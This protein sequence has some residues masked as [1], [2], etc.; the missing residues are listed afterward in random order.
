[1][2]EELRP[3]PKNLPTKLVPIPKQVEGDGMFDCMPADI[4]LI[5]I[6]RAAKALGE[7]SPQHVR[8]LIDEGLLKAG[9]INDKFEG[10][11]KDGN[12]IDPRL[13]MRI[14]R[15]SVVGYWREM[16]RLTGEDDSPYVDMPDV[17]WWR[18]KI[19]ASMQAEYKNL[20]KLK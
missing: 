8:D 3:M 6:R 14:E 7:T 13:T 10:T 9:P 11:D 15:Y 17:T 16:C 1:M 19:R 5:S 12:T 20:S 18:L 2:R 4:K